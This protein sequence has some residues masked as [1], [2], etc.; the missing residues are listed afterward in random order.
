MKYIKD[1]CNRI[2]FYRASHRPQHEKLKFISNR[3][4]SD[5]DRILRVSKF[6]WKIITS[7]K[8]CRENNNRPSDFFSTEMSLF[9]NCFPIFNIFGTHF[10]TN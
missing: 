10:R 1:K 3:D 5:F 4:L 9:K 7:L 2:H 8:V 6:C